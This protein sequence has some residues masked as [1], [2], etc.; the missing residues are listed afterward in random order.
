M[1]ACTGC[2][3][4]KPTREFPKDS[5]SPRNK[6]IGFFRGNPTVVQAAARYVSERA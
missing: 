4:S 1:K 2:G 6:G 5:R 3:V